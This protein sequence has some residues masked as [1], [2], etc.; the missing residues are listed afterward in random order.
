MVLKGRVGSSPTF[1]TTPCLNY[2]CVEWQVGSGEAKAMQWPCRR[3]MPSPKDILLINPWIFDFTAYDFWTRPLGLLYVGALL[4]EHTN[5][6]LHLVDCLDRYHPQLPKKPKTKEDGR[7]PFFKQEVSKPSALRDVPRKFSRYGIPLTLFVDQLDQVPQPDMVLVTCTLTYW[8]PGA[9][10]AVEL[11]RQKFGRVP[12]ALGGVY[13]TLLPG[14]AKDAIDADFVLEGPGERKLLP[15]MR[16]V[17]G[18]KFCPDL[19]F[20]EL[21]TIPRPAFDLLRDRNTLPVLTSRGCPYGCSYCASSLLFKG[22]DQESPE[23]IVEHIECLHNV[24]RTKNIAFYDDALLLNKTKHII[25]ILE[26]IIR[27]EIPLAFHTPNGLHV[28][29]IDADLASLFKRANFKSLFLSQES[30][31]KKVLEDSC[32]KVTSFDL[33]VA[34]DHLKNVGYKPSEINV[35]LMVGL[36]GQGVEGIRESVRRVQALGA[37]PRLAYFSPVPGTATWDSLITKGIVQSDVDPL[38]HNKLAFPYTWGEMAPS[39]F[40]SLHDLISKDPGTSFL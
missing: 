14:H 12:V 30:F 6:R 38:L 13:A 37:R 39:E 27:K 15:L 23:R 1:R 19:R 8:Y 16:E 36:P 20:E 21:G 35:Y 24:H 4:R 28:T 34:L 32:S 31:E 5:S 7:G 22:F 33:G 3:Q 17:F 11:I 2:S 29:E 26:R 18:D 9:Q 10:L 25:P 40:E